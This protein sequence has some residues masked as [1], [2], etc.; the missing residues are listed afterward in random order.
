[1]RK[2]GIYSTFFRCCAHGGQG[3]HPERAQAE[4]YSLHHWVPLGIVTLPA[5]AAP[6]GTAFLI[7]R[8]CSSVRTLLPGSSSVLLFALSVCSAAS[9]LWCDCPR[10]SL[11]F[12][13]AS[14]LPKGEVFSLGIGA[15]FQLK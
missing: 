14:L 5:K 7:G 9:A 11:P 8:I 12:T 1:M 3:P 10:Q 4:R 13:I 2:S 6:F 15:P